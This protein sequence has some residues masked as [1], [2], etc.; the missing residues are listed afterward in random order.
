MTNKLLLCFFAISI[1]G[2]KSATT[3]TKEISTTAPTE[4]Y[5]QQMENINEAI[6]FRATG[7]EPFWGI[8]ISNEKLEFTSLVEGFE[9]MTSTYVAPAKAM[10][11]NVKMYRATTAMGEIKIQIK[12]Q[13]CT[14]S[15]SGQISPYTVTVEIIKNKNLAPTVF[16]GCG[17]Y[18][19]DV[20][21]HDIWVLETLNNKKAAVTDF[22]KELPNLEIN[23]SKNT[24]SGFSGCNTMA[25]SIF[26][27]NGLLRF[28]DIMATKMYCGDGNKESEF[29]K[30]LQSATTY[31]IE[32]NRLTLSNPS[33][34]QLIFKKVD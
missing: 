29:L 8:K 2:C 33:G 9:K 7:N 30:A 24:F 10:D 26:F 20:R 12:A 5:K 17:H 19:T 22:R 34:V 18:I 4:A 1:L 28:T 23:T 25:G 6:Y 15:M 11:A 14:D 31:E 16:N 27:E 21:L 13:E 3:S 32:N